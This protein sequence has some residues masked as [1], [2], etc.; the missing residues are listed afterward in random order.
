MSDSASEAASNPGDNSS[1]TSAEAAPPLPYR[2]DGK[3]WRDDWPVLLMMAG[4][5][6]LGV[7]AWLKS[8]ALVPVHWNIHNEVD[9]WG[10]SWMNTLMPLG[11]NLFIYLLM[12]YAPTWDKKQKISGPRAIAAYRQLRILM[13]V[14][15]AAIH[16][17]LCLLTLGYN[18]DVPLVIRLTLPPMFVGIGLLIPRIPPNGI[19][20]FRTPWTMKNAR[21]WERT[22]LLAGNLLIVGGIIAFGGAFLPPEPGFIVFFAA[23]MLAVIIPLVYSAI[24]FKREGGETGDPLATPREDEKPQ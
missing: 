2:V 9:G 17:G 4:S 7:Y 3:M 24:I 21:V 5:A 1:S 13:V 20:G 15:F 14:V 16:I 10:P 23:I 6:A 19:A 22:H 12:L 11:I 8:D 18:V